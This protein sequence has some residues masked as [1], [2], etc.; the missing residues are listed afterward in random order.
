MLSEYLRY[1]LFLTGTKV[2]CAEGD[3]GACTVLRYFPYSNSKSKNLFLP[4]NSCIATVAQLDGSSLVTIDAL[5]DMT[6][7]QKAMV[8][9][10]GSQCGFCTPGFV[11]A[12][13]GLVEKKISTAKPA[14]IK[15]QEAK[16][17]LT[18]NLCR[19]T[20]YQPI[21]DAAK[22]INLSECESLAE[23]FL[24]PAQI[25]EL[26]STIKIP[27][28]LTSPEF[29]FYAPTNLKDA[30]RFLAKNKSS[31]ILGSATDLGVLHNKQKKQLTQVLSL[32]LIENLYKIEKVGSGRM[33]VGARITLTELRNKMKALI[34]EF[35]TFLDLFASPQIKNVATLVGNV[36]NASP[37]ADTPPFLMTLNTVLEIQSP[38][39][40]RFVPIENFFLDYRKT[41]LKS[42]ELIAALHFDI[43]KKSDSL[44]AYKVS[45][46]K[47]LDISAVNF[48]ARVIW[49]NAQQNQIKEIFLSV[50]GVAAVTLRLSKTELIF[51][52]KTLTPELFESALTQLHQEIQPLSDLRASQ[53]FR[54]V[55]VENL[56]LKFFR[57]KSH[58]QTP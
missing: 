18:G 32:H 3:C 22:N 37:I 6:P 17:A 45:Q 44:A 31:C 43:P 47:D 5:T 55:V 33:R 11:M 38:K 35:A 16:N 49:K 40:I 34:P 10:H 48:A 36:A 4:I 54:H 23:K 39:G 52:N 27:L 1:H 15:I 20:G 58:A 57:E 53:Q 56:F 9:C 46:R 8:T 13:H 26:R 7:V 19:C 51:K 25:R 30:S 12:L 41:N 21:L 29:S 24:T 42:G 14:P 28:Q 50:G 2:V